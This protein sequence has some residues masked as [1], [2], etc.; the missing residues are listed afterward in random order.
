MLPLQSQEVLC[1]T[2]KSPVASSKETRLA[3]NL[4]WSTT[5]TWTCP[6]VST[7]QAQ[8]RQGLMAVEAWKTANSGRE[9]WTE[10]Q[11][12]GSPERHVT[13][14]LRNRT[15]KS[16]VHTFS[17]MSSHLLNSHLRDGEFS[18]WLCQEQRETDPDTRSN[19]TWSS[20]PLLIPSKKG[21]V[22]HWPALLASLY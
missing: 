16:Y 19:A 10:Q 8:V 13:R 7:L 4:L 9:L 17:Q 11:D 18:L 3:S 14:A 20:P 6:S 22:Q 1:L 15:P 2:V 5:L 12:R 21:K